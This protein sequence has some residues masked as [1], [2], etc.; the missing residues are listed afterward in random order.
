MSPK[1]IED[2]SKN[3]RWISQFKKFSRLSVNEILKNKKKHST[4]THMNAK[5]KLKKLK[6]FNVCDLY[7][8]F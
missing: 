1:L 4:L 8:L 7:A 5:K 2:S 6:S 3:G